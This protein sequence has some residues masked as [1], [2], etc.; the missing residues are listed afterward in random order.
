[1]NWISRLFRKSKLENQL[2]SEL[3]F[4]VEQQTADNI[5]AGMNPEEARRSALA[6][7][8]GLEYIKEETRD[9][10]G[11]QFIESLLQDIRFAFRMLHK[12]PGFTAVAVL[13]L[14]LGIGANTAIFSVVD[15]VLLKPLTYPRPNRIVQL[16]LT[17]SGH[18]AIGC[19]PTEFNILRQQG[20]ALEDVSGYESGSAGMDLTGGALPEQIHAIRVTVD[21]FRLFGA[22]IIQGRTFTAQEDQP[23]AG[24]FAVMSYGLWQRRFGGDPGI[25]G[26]AISLDSQPYTV[27]GI[28]GPGFVG[29]GFVAAPVDVWI[30]FQIDP[31][32]SDQGHT[33]VAAARMR[34][35]VTLAQAISELQLAAIQFRQKFP[36]VKGPQ[37]GF[38]AELL[39]DAMVSGIRSSLLVLLGA[40]SFVLLIA[41]ANVAN[42][43]L[44][45]ATA[46]RREIAIRAGLGAGRNRLVR[47]L[48]TESVVLFFIGGGLGLILGM[49]GVRAL[50]AMSPGNI[51]RVGPDAS[52]VTVDWRILVFTV[53]FSLV[54][55]IVFGM[56]PALDASRADVSATLNESGLRSGA[57]IR[58]N[59]ARAL[60]VISETALALILLVGAGLLIRSFVAL[61]AVDPGFDPHN[62]LTLRMSLTGPRFQTT[63]GVAQ[64]VRDSVERLDSLPEVVSAG[65][66]CCLPL[67][68][69]PGLPFIVIGRPL[70]NS[71]SHGRGDWAS[72]SPDY[73]NVLGMPILRGRGFSERDDAA[74]PPV[75]IV[76]QAMARQVWP[77]E[78]PLNARLL[79]GKG[80][81]PVFKDVERQVVGIVGDVHD[82]G[83]NRNPGPAMYLPVSQVPDAITA[84]SARVYPIAWVVRT[85]VEPQSLVTEVENELRAASGGL[86]V[87]RIRTMDEILVQSTASASFNMLLLTIFAVSALAL[88]AIGIYGLMAYSVRQRR[89]EIGIRMALGATQGNVRTMVVLQGMRLALIGVGLGIVAA[90]GLT[91]LMTSFLFGVKTWDPMVFAIVPI[92]L[93]A[94]ALFAVWIPAYHATR[95]DPVIAIR[96]E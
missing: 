42:L 16:L 47:Q 82:A 55:G 13:T 59:K 58:Q 23:N 85:R 17:H 20:S 26:K 54:T 18:A 65:S 28:V 56:I 89:Q 12:S 83:L 10:R 77:N 4:H 11:T 19:S 45:R 79:I 3:R 32:S 93:S 44:V 24:H 72:V 49:T 7:F 52:T 70:G 37:D 76:N 73:F 64:L 9:A 68:G 57:S 71:P 46:R 63:S 60:L 53:G 61:R 69:G 43:L 34:P 80:M 94:V 90:F 25:V 51:P 62:V 5:A 29:P 27:T 91:R 8:G 88:A 35:G 92:V 21:Y 31:N 74:A 40:V 41:C 33:F 39:Q 95:V 14:A 87:G 38:S 96:Y 48:L 81:G 66:T 15:A 36:G 22:P 75:V 67:E 50:L 86:P 30:P 78:D 2:D 84:L 6:Q 1:V